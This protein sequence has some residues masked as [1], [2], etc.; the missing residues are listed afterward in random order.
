MSFYYSWIYPEEYDFAKIQLDFY[1]S[2]RNHIQNDNTLNENVKV[3]KL[4][5]LNFIIDC[6]N[7]SY[8]IF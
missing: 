8:G 5:R 6:I 3:L 2:K 7:Y 1:I 4:K